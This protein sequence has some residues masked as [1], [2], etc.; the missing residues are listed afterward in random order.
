M[1]ITFTDGSV[2]AYED[3]A[4][5]FGAQGEVFRSRDGKHAVKLYYP[6]TSKDPELIK[7]IDTLINNA[8]IFVAKPF[9]Q[10]SEGDYAAMLGVNL[11]GFF[12]FTQLAIAEMEKRHGGH[13]GF[14]SLRV[15][16]PAQSRTATA[17]NRPSAFQ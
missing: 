17:T 14:S 6:D 1:D 4:F 7:R 13:V 15:A 9:T 3:S 2:E 5:A 16:S 11:S 10:Y 8:G 12:H